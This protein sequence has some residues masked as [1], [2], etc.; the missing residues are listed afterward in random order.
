VSA[1]FALSLQ[2]VLGILL[3][4]LVIRRDLAQLSSDQLA[5]AWNDASLWSAVV[6]F[7]P[8]SM[9][10]HFARTRR[11][12]LGLALGLGWAVVGL[13]ASALVGALFA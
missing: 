11:S 12:L 3:P 13:I 4:A 7:G 1:V 2:I 8:L 5:Q 9:I 10:V 6:T